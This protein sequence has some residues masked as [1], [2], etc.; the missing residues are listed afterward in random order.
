MESLH[1][2]R[3]IINKQN[4][5]KGKKFIGNFEDV[6]QFCSQLV[7]DFGIPDKMVEFQCCYKNECDSWNEYLMLYTISKENTTAE[8]LG[9][10]LTVLGRLITKFRKFGF[11]FG[12]QEIDT[13]LPLNYYILIYG[14]EEKDREERG[15][16]KK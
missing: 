4:L 10:G 15:E 5:R 16:D 8:G 7:N 11:D 12:I 9:A 13:S 6:P 1:T 3:E 14:L 2:I